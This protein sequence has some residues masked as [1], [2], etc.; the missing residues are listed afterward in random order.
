MHQHCV[1]TKKLKSWLKSLL[2]CVREGGDSCTC[3]I[4]Q[5][6]T[7]I[8]HG[9]RRR[10][11]GPQ[12]APG[13]SIGGANPL[14]C[15]LESDNSMPFSGQHYCCC[16]PCTGMDGCSV[17]FERMFCMLTAECV[18]GKPEGQWQHCSLTYIHEWP[19][20]V[21]GVYAKDVTVRVQCHSSFV[22]TSSW[23]LACG[24]AVCALQACICV[25]L[26]IKV[27]P[28]CTASSVPSCADM[29]HQSLLSRVS[30]CSRCLCL[31]HSGYCYAC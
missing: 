28:K 29:T 4:L 5:N 9:G 14:Q 17:V 20:I 22:R 10:A 16:R 2:L 19:P 6:T 24:P 8:A 25:V 11:H 15:P 23:K 12:S 30:M 21:E 31:C 27:G 1:S 18:A 13:T 26:P 3:T 7:G